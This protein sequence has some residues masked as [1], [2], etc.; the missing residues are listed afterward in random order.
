MP[1]RNSNA[2]YHHFKPR[3][4]PNFQPAKRPLEAKS[5]LKVNAETIVHEF[6]RNW[7]EK[8]ARIIP[9]ESQAQLKSVYRPSSIVHW[10][11]GAINWNV[12]LEYVCWGLAGIALAML[13]TLFVFGPTN[14]RE[15]LWG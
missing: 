2:D 7:E 1:R 10:F 9:L 11:F 6:R 4:D 15:F 8:E 12:A 3:W 5:N 14:W 13:I